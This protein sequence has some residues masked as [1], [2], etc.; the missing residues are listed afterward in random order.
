MNPSKYL[1][2]LFIHIFIGILLYLFRSLSFVYFISIVAFFTIKLFGANASNKP[3]FAIYACCYIVGSEVMIRMTGGA[4]FYEA[5]KYLVIVFSL[6][7]MFYRG[8]NIK[9]VSYIFYILFLIPAIYVTLYSVEGALNLRK[10]IAFNL[11]GPVCLGIAAIFCYGFKVNK[12]ILNKLFLYLVLPLVTTLTYI[13]LYN[14]DVARIAT[15]TSSNFAASGG[16]G[17]NQ[18]STVLG[19]GMFIMTVRFFYF[20]KTRM[21]KIIDLVL[22]ALFSFRAI[23]TFSRGGVFTAVIMIF[24][25]IA[26]MFKFSNRKVRTKI[27]VSTFVFLMLAAFTWIY[28][29]IQTQG[30]IDKRYANQNSVG[31]VKSDVTTGRG[32]LFLNEI[33][34]FKNNPFFGV[35]VGKI[36]DIRFQKTGVHAASHN[37]MSRIISEHGIFGI[38]SFIILLLAPLFLRIGLRNNIFFFSFYAFWFLTINHS[39]MRIAAPAFIYALSLLHV[40]NEKPIIHRKQVIEQE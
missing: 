15:G 40:V 21:S 10:A 11:S 37:E 5:S 2:L 12:I 34:E 32:V 7:G 16:F 1:Q 29:S 26:L 33:E 31:Q 36:K 27:I 17:P 20:S 24:L 35:G 8:F 30:F 39:S 23:S 22:L 25:F 13:I 3:Y 14:P 18:V 38:L 9:A 19:L 4:V 6:V 28:T